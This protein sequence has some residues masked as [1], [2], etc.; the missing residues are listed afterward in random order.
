M[1]EIIERLTPL[2][3]ASAS[4]E[5]PR[6]A[7]SSRTRSAMR[8]FKSDAAVASTMMDTVSTI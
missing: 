8:W 3:L 2:W 4:R 7:R 1:S 5:R 6:A